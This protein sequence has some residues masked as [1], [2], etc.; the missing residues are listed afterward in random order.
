MT[1]LVIAEREKRRLKVLEGARL[2]N[3]GPMSWEAT[4]WEERIRE[5]SHSQSGITITR[6]RIS[7]ENGDEI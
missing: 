5:D 2:A 3:G 1:R 4:K 7:Y 6:E